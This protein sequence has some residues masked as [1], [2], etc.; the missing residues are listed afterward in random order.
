MERLTEKHFGNEGYY[1]KCSE[2]CHAPQ[3]CID[4]AAF[5]KLVDRL[6]AYEDT[7]LEPEDFKKAFNEGALL[8]LTAQYL[9]TTPDR[10]HEWV[11]ADKEDRL[12]ALPAKTVWELTLDAGP[13][14]DMKCPVDVW[15]EA[16]GCDF[17]G[18]AKLFAYERPCTQERLKELGKT[19]FLTR[20]EA[21]TALAGE[22][23]KHE[24]D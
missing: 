23:G 4:C 8:K 1:M 18:K 5:D 24:T 14:C 19:V 21:E 12:V 10:L 11:K 15:D 3:D 6:A 16:L 2:D 13:D 20:E 7:G 22:G 17:C 9:G